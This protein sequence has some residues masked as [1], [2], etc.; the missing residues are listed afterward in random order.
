MD[1]ESDC[2]TCD[3]GTFCPVGSGAETPCAPGTYSPNT[4]QEVCL[5]CAAGKYQD[6]PGQTA[7][8]TCEPGNYCAERAASDLA[9]PLAATNLA[10][11]LERMG[12]RMR[13]GERQR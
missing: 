2:I 1:D 8:K 11:S 9:S 3:V 7:C 6:R 10:Q 13:K 5:V 12:R 4:K